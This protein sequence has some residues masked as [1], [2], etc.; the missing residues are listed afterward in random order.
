MP[1]GIEPRPAGVGGNRAYHYTNGI[2]FF[3]DHYVGNNF[4][5]K[6]VISLK[7][8]R[9]TS[10]TRAWEKR[11]HVPPRAPAWACQCS[12]SSSKC[13]V[14]CSRFVSIFSVIFIRKLRINYPVMNYAYLNHIS[15]HWIFG[16]C[17]GMLYKNHK[18]K[19]RIKNKIL[20]VV[21]NI[22]SWLQKLQTYMS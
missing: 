6:D 13:Y 14:I 7:C 22:R 2:A 17:L 1:T 11:G 15:S 4:T 12:G 5:K 10:V 20:G 16:I 3:L 9:V 21:L 18:L 19:H 8:F